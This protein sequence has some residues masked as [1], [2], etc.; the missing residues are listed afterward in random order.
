MIKDMSGNK[1]SAYKKAKYLLVD[2]LDCAEYKLDDKFN[3]YNLKNC[4]QKE[5]DSIM[6]HIEKI[7]DRIINSLGQF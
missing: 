1:T 2:S 5:L 4:T 7:R 6:T 3:T